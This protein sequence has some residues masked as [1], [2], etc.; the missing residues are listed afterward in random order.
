LYGLDVK[1][2][3]GRHAGAFL[4]LHRFY[5][6]SQGKIIQPGMQVR[7]G[8]FK[9]TVDRIFF[10]NVAFSP[11]L[12]FISHDEAFIPSPDFKVD[13]AFGTESFSVS[14]RRRQL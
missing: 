7:R 3:G 1:V 12:E 5:H 10:L 13:D 2:Q 11:C 4:I 14:S 6:D 8:D 9:L